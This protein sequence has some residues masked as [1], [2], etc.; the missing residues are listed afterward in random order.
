MQADLSPSYSHEKLENPSFADFV[1]VFEDLWRKCVFAQADLLLRTPNSDIA[2]MTVLCPYFEAIAGYIAGEDTNGRARE[3]F[4][5]GFCSVFRSDLPEI[6]K[7]AEAVYKYVRCGLAHEGMLRHKVNYSRSGAKAFF[8]TY[9]KAADATLDI[10]ADVVSIIV[11]PLRVYEGVIH[12]F[13]GYIRA[14]REAKD[15]A[16][17]TAFQNTVDRQWALGTGGNIIG[18]TEAEFLG[19]P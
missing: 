14:L 13:D 11:N 4:V 12:H 10:D 17:T 2:A 3:F 5:K 9:R 19:R 8:L 15:K 16:L 18:M 7:A 1:D 6:P